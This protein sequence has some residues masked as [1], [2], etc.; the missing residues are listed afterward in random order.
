MRKMLP[1]LAVLLALAAA[2]FAV[3]RFH[4]DGL[5]R[6]GQEPMGQ[7]DV[8]A[9]KAVTGHP[10]GTDIPRIASAEEFARLSV[11]DYVTLQPVSAVPAGV[12]HLKSWVSPDTRRRY[13]GRASGAPKKKPEL[14]ESGFALPLDY[15]PYYL[16]ELRD[17][18][19]ILAEIPEPDADAIRRGREVTLPIGEKRT[20]RGTEK[21]R[22]VCEV[23][24]ADPGSVFFA[25]DEAWY[26]SHS[27][28]LLLM[29]IGVGVLVFFVTGVCLL[30]LMEKAAERMGKHAEKQ[31]TGAGN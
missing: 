4:P 14:V 25:F 12:W 16:L 17:G 27:L 11:G 31:D 5:L 13:K 1:Y 24:G 19:Y 30:L 6:G 21:L 20:V 7:S 8:E 23:Y 29:Q 22:A 9:G 3:S 2:A 26:Q 28:P 15:D 10:A 18:S